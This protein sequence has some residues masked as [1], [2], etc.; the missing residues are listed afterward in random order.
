MTSSLPPDYFLPLQKLLLKQVPHKLVWALE[1]AG[2]EVDEAGRFMIRDGAVLR[3]MDWDEVEKFI[4]VRDKLLKYAEEDH[5]HGGHWFPSWDENLWEICRLRVANPGVPIEFMVGGSN[6]SA[7]TYFAGAFMVNAM[8]QC[9]K[10]K[11]FWSLAMDEP[12]S[13]SI[14]QKALNYWLP[15]AYK[16]DSGG[17]KTTGVQKLKYNPAGG[18]TDNRFT[19]GKG[20]TM[21]CRFWSAAI[22]TLEGNRP[23][24]VWSDEELPLTWMERISD[25]RMLTE[26]EPSALLCPGW[27]ALL[28]EKRQNP[29]MLFPRDRIGDL[30]MGLHLNTYTVRD[31][32]SATFRAF[33]DGGKVM[34]N[35]E[36]DR[37]LLPRRNRAG[38]ILGGEILP[39]LIHSKAKSRRIRF[40]YAWENPLGGNWE[41]MKQTCREKQKSRSEILW[42]CYGWAEAAV[43]S[44]FPNYNPQIHN[45]PVSWLPK[46]G[47]WYQT[48][49]PVCNGGK[50]WFMLWACV[51]AEQ[52][53]KI[54]PGDIFIAHEWPQENDF[55]PGYGS[56]GKWALP[57]GKDNQGI[58]GPA[59]KGL[60][61]GLR[62]KAEEI[63]RI[64][65]KLATWQ[66]L[67]YA[68]DPERML[69]FVDTRI[70]DSRAANTEKDGQD[71]GTTL[72]QDLS[73]HNGLDFIQAGMDSGAESGSTNVRPGLQIIDDR[74]SFDRNLAKLDPETGWLEIDLQDGVG[75]K[76]RIADHC[77]NLIEAILNYPGA[78]FPKSPWKDPID[79][80]RYLVIA[81]P[82]H[83]SA[84]DLETSGGGGY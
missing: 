84:E 73:E 76:V 15:N 77:T 63:R 52:Y 51:A 5:Y 1:L 75:P 55:I 71:V 36:A 40:N 14:Q 28:E 20:V 46:R 24:C 13:T 29:A 67:P 47:T 54:S 65:T 2:D 42:W 17:V 80:L 66:G 26:A 38:E 19:L 22:E 53:G 44:P 37:D 12:Q 39:S 70:M 4:R 83:V 6:G 25:K 30:A 61:G 10:G 56:L 50:T 16:P 27:A 57:G 78:N 82:E 69:F 68:N 21:E 81:R 32:T 8:M 45:R 58:A 64:E 49:D 62:F 43:D 18:F 72:I 59:Q 11:T 48:V 9:T 33:V 34:R 3:W 23:Y 31:G 35:I 74:F 41:G 60:S 7:K 79:C